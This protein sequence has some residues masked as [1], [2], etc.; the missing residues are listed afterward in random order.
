MGI[1]SKLELPSVVVTI[2]AGIENSEK[3][4]I[5]KPAINLQRQKPIILPTQIINI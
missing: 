3:Y 1:P 2:G 4:N 5:E